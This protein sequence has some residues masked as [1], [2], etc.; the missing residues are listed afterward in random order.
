MTNFEHY[1][2]GHSSYYGPSRINTP[3]WL[4]AVEFQNSSVGLHVLLELPAVLKN[5]KASGPPVY[6][7][8]LSH[9][10][11]VGD[12]DKADTPFMW[13]LTDQ[14]FYEYIQD[15]QCK[16][17]FI[18]GTPIEDTEHVWWYHTH[19]KLHNHVRKNVFK[20]GYGTFRLSRTPPPTGSFP[21]LQTVT[22]SCSVTGSP[23]TLMDF[24]S[25]AVF[26]IGH[27]PTAV[28]S[29]FGRRENEQVSHISMLERMTGKPPPSPVETIKP[30]FGFF[31]K[32][33]T[34]EEGKKDKLNKRNSITE[35]V[36]NVS[37]TMKQSTKSALLPPP[38]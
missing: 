8:V 19:Y 28:S 34:S 38:E 18:S 22:I 24:S 30:L 15:N 33:K 2:E 21:I 3:L 23:Q 1:Q 17:T 6:A 29:L 9:M 26:Q 13:E 10:Q 16:I 27:Q 5:T 25:D 14:G 36:K 12:D 35:Y 11:I 37:Y 20:M 32:S 4:K 31:G 7:M